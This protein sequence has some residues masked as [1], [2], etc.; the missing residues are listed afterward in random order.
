MTIKVLI[1]DDH[2]IVRQGLKQTLGDAADVLVVDEADN[3]VDCVRLAQRLRPDV[4]L[5]DIALPGRDGLETLA[6]LRVHCPKLAVLMLSTYPERQY[7]VRCIQQGA[8]GYLH[9]SADADTLLQAIRQA[10]AGQMALTP[11]VAEAMAVSMS[12]HREK[13]G[14]ELLSHRE[15]QVF[16]LLA[17]GRSVG[18]IAEQLALSSNTVSTY[19][20]RI[21]DKT[22][23]A[24]DVELALYAVRQRLVEP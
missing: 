9:K 4:L 11:A 21:L 24:N 22:G 16:A 1:C 20:A 13:A 6:E 2:W 12:L 18:Q 5:L 3:G 14:H 8:K 7:A 10:A 15:Q 19:R 23:A 17:R